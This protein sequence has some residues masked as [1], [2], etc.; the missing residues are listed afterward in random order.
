MENHNTLRIELRRYFYFLHLSK[1][2]GFY[3][4]MALFCLAVKKALRGCH[5][6]N[7]LRELRLEQLV[8][9]LEIQNIVETMIMGT[10]GWL[11]G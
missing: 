9:I 2:K 6:E 4:P 5:P 8:K 11:S 3:L 1:T 7:V 10:L